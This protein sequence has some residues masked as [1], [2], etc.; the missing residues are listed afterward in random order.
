MEI[1]AVGD[2][3]S[4]TGIA[5]T[6]TPD[7]V[8]DIMVPAGAQYKL[9]L[10]FLW[11]HD[12]DDP[13]GLVTSIKVTS[14]GLEIVGKIAKG[15]T[16]G[17]D[18]AFALIKAGLVRG[19]SIGFRGLAYEDIPGSYGRKFTKWELF[20]VS[21]VTVAANAECSITSI[22]SI[23][24]EFLAKAE[25]GNTDKSIKPAGKSVR[26]LPLGDTGKSTPPELSKKGLPKMATVA[27][28]IVALEAT[29]EQKKASLSTIMQKSIDEGRST[30]AAEADEF[31][32]LEGEVVSLQKDLDRLKKMEALQAKSAVEPPVVRA[33]VEA[34]GIKSVQ[35]GG[36][37]LKSQVP[38]GIRFARF[39]SAIG[40]SRGSLHSAMEYSKRWE[41]TTPEVVDVMKAAVAAGTTTSTSW[42]SPL[43]V[44]DNMVSEFISFLRPQT[45]LGKIPGIRSV[46]FN[47]S[48]P[49]QTAGSSV[50]WVGQGAPKP[51]S[52]LAFSQQTLGIAKAAG[53]VVLSQELV[54]SSDPS[55]E[56]VVRDD[57][58]AAMAQFL[59]DAFLNP[60]T[61]A[62]TNVSPAS[63]TNGSSYFNAGGTDAA[64]A[65]ADIRKL[66]NLY[67]TANLG[68]D[69]AVWVMKPGVALTLSMMLN[70]LG[71]PF[72][73]GM[74]VNGGTLAGLPVI[75]TNNLTQSVLAAGATPPTTVGDHIMLIKAN[76]ILLADDGGITIDASDQA[77]LQMD[78][79]PTAGPAQLVSLWQNNL[80]GIR[81][82]RFI[83]WKKRRA[84]ATTYLTGVNYVS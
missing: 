25:S 26:L 80:V 70:A 28:Q 55:A 50:G 66:Y 72:F 4:F 48:I 40:A 45:V 78:T 56:M 38:E 22:K 77:S 14:K 69:G 42:A 51:V 76:E 57:L 84:A 82:E 10:P 24:A 19:L 39:A 11:Q 79:A 59:D 46:P 60:A 5:S 62:V 67:A 54:R 33:V 71:Q 68:L 8:D 12:H 21:S 61:A 27:E 32:T 83:N 16:S 53:I 35:T 44:Y 7:R 18:E 75:V 81:A 74:S 20:E 58:A 9:P 73:E 65:R 29:V 49:E 63:V 43:V 41:S 37:G 30:D 47:I 3:G 36:I 15:V 31:D 34:N 1:K 6:P 2:D 64:A 13:I 52:A 23:D 17:I